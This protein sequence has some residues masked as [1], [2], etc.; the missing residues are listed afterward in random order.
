VSVCLSGNSWKSHGI[1]LI[2]LENFIISNVI[3]ARGEVLWFV[4][5]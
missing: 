4:V 3:V 2:V 1:W 5:H